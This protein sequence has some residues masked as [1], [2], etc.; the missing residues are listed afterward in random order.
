MKR[1]IL[2]DLQECNLEI[3]EYDDLIIKESLKV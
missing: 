3:R 1:K 2:K